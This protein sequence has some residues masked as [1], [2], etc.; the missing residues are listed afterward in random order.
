MT[1]DQ[2]ERRDLDDLS[3]AA[4]QR[5]A[6]ARSDEAAAAAAL[7]LLA[8]NG[9]ALTVAEL[10][11]RGVARD[12]VAALVD[13]DANGDKRKR[14]RARLTMV[15]IAGAPEVPTVHLTSVGWSAT[16]RPS[17]REVVPTSDT[18]EH[19]MAPYRL[20]AWL[21][22]RR[23]ATHAVG[24]DVTMTWGPSCRRFSEEVVA[25]AWAR[26]RMMN[27]QSGALGSLTGGLIPDALIVERWTDANN[28]TQAW[29][30]QPAGADDL[31]ETLV[32][33]EY[34]HSGKSDEP[35]RAKVERWDAASEQLGACAAVIWFV[36][37]ASVADRLIALGV[38]DPLRRA[39]QLLVPAAAVGLGS[40]TSV[41]ASRPEWW[42]LRL[43]AN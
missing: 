5:A 8:D 28:Y 36:N 31:A 33:V 41:E 23:D 38:G 34:E 10:L 22:D 37:S 42:P 40:G 26:L 14:V 20:A 24:A 11:R 27:D 17:G 39:R 21:D 6:A 1:D 13:E 25:R 15:R 7:R 29:G 3:S 19:A 18:V 2:A 4:Q 35:L 32:A 12:T 16:G 43:R 30:K 9:G